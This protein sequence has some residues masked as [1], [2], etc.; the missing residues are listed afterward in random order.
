MKIKEHI[1]SYLFTMLLINLSI[2]AYAQEY[3]KHIVK[4]GDTISS[5]SK[6]YGISESKI[7]ELNPNARQ[8]I[9]VGMELR[10]P[11]ET[12]DLKS[13]QGSKVGVKPEVSRNN[14]STEE[15]SSTRRLSHANAREK[16][17]VISTTRL[18]VR[19]KPEAKSSVIG[20]LYPNEVIDILSIT[21][22]WAKIEYKGRMAYVSSKY[23]KKIE[24]KEDV[25]EYEVHE[26]ESISEISQMDEASQ[27]EIQNV[28]VDN[29]NSLLKSLS[30]DFVP[31]V[32]GGFSNFVSDKVTPKGG[33]GLGVDLTF[34]FIAENSI[35]FIPKDYFMDFSLG[36]SLKGS[37]AFPMHY[38][39][40]KLSPIGYRKDFSEFS[41]FGKVGYLTGYTT[42][43]IET[44]QYTFNSNLDFGVLAEMGVEYNGIG[45]ALAYERGLANVCDSNLKLRNSG[46]FLKLS[47]RLFDV[48]EVFNN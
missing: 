15:A 42:S 2:N 34:Q 18:N 3:I 25:A 22:S 37:A 45:I 32:A 29:D 48:R 12:K 24:V 4:R 35:L 39:T 16:Y 11:M 44:G 5:I 10:L 38:I 26:K 30:I 41:L 33:F 36:Y 19:S 13:E 8:F 21:N 46:L 40:M 43:T 7:I 1:I 9:Y 6:S 28:T 14:I 17:E 47:C 31:S 27:P 23:I 20:S